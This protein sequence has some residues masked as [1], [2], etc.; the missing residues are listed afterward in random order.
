MGRPL[1]LTPAD[2]PA[3]RVVR[4]QRRP[5]WQR[6]AAALFFAL[7]AV[8]LVALA[9]RLDWDGVGAALAGMPL[10]T[11]ALALAIA[12][13]SYGLVSCFDLLGRHWT[14][15]RLP[16]RQVLAVAFVSYAFNLNLGSLIGA[17]AFRYRLYSRL[18]LSNNV[19]TRVLALSLVTNWLGY[20]VL[21]GGAFTF[22]VIAPPEGWDVGAGALRVLGVVL[23]ATAAAYLVI[24]AR[25]RRREWEF[26]G[27]VILLPPLRLAALQLALSLANWLL[28]ALLLTVL[29]RFRIDYPTVLGT[30]LMAA[31]AGV[32]THIPGGLGVI[33]AVFL[34]MLGARLAE[35]PLLAALLCYRAIHYLLPLLAACV[36][37]VRLEARARRRHLPATGTRLAEAGHRHL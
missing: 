2:T 36:V 21:A 8:L 29:L 30:F 22:G 24:C 5:A 6:V 35:G 3:P 27:H 28:T 20:L 11:L 7:V 34:A 31:L 13:L 19:I 18:G 25:A 4:A 1:A 33:E 14:R 9:R 15:H 16:T 10:R 26:R 12:S 37:A 17:F 32:I 23:L